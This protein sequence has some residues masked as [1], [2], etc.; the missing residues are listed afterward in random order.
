MRIEFKVPGEPKGKARPRL[1]K[2]TGTIY[3]PS[4]T[5]EYED[6]IARYCQDEYPGMVDPGEPVAIW[7]TAC[8][9]IPKGDSRRTR[10]E[11]LCGE[12]LPT[13]KPDA[14][15]ILKVVL[16]ALNGTL[17]NDDTQVV[18]AGINKVYSDFPCIIV[19]VTTKGDMYEF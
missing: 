1:N 15:N 13:K 2:Y 3:T 9:G 5:H 8:C 18:R 4:K 11:K 10:I 7:V 19:T 12:L 16:D 6:M 17:Y 14:D